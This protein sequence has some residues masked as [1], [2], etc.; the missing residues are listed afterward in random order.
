MRRG[1]LLALILALAGCYHARK[2]AP[3]PPPPPPPKTPL[4]RAL[5]GTLDQ[6]CLPRDQARVRDALCRQLRASDAEL[7]KVLGGNARQMI[8]RANQKPQLR[9]PADDALPK[10]LQRINVGDSGDS[11]ASA[12]SAASAL[13][14]EEADARR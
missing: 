12:A 10:R 13:R 11:A 1:L 2:P 8:L 14:P 9:F 4:V 5:M 3:A 6:M 7:D